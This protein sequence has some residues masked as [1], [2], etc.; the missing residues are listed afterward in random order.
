MRVLHVLELGSREATAAKRRLIEDTVRW[1]EGVDADVLWVPGRAAW[2]AG[3]VRRRWREMEAEGGNFDVVHAW[4]AG[5]VGVARVLR[6]GVPIVFTP[7]VAGVVGEG[8]VVEKAGYGTLRFA[9]RRRGG[10]GGGG[11]A[12]VVAG[13]SGAAVERWRGAGVEVEGV[14]PVGVSLNAVDLAEREAVRAA[15]GVDEDA[16]VLG[17]VGE[18][19]WGAGAVTG[20]MVLCLVRESHVRKASGRPELYLMVHPRQERRRRVQRCLGNIGERR[21]VFQ[22]AAAGEPWAVMPRWD[23]GLVVGPEGDG[24][25]R[26]WA[27]ASGV[28]MVIPRS[29]AA[30]A[31]LVHEEE[32]MIALD[33]GYRGWT[34]EVDRLLME[35]GL[36]ERVR[37]GARAWAA[38]EHDPGVYAGRVR[39]LYERAG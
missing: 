8:G 24:V 28:A 37:A 1:V 36:L 16:V 3:W 18:P 20:M 32:A 4:S 7:G 26:A 14:L 19:M 21:R 12:V 35:P 27:A 15:W 39:E 22:D 29:E 13:L 5:G 11:G 9:Q 30:A 33:D 31:G 2:R 25:A 17:L 23:V 34:R 6:P 38:R 10:G